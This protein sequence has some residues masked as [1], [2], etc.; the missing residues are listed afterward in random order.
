LAG[1]ERGREGKVRFYISQYRLSFSLFRRV[2]WEREREM[3]NAYSVLSLSSSV[4]LC[5]CVCVYWQL[6]KH[7]QSL[8]MRTRT[9]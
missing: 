6:S 3:Y 1:W 2:I 8:A 7:G 5:V 9:N 4:C